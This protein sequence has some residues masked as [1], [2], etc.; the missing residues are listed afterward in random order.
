MRLLHHFTVSSTLWELLAADRSLTLKEEVL[1]GLPSTLPRTVIC[2]SM[3]NK[4]KT[5][6]VSGCGATVSTAK[7]E[8]VDHAESYY[9]E[10]LKDSK[11]E[12]P[13]MYPYNS[14]YSFELKRRK[15][16]N[17]EPGAVQ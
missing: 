9:D 8:S 7:Q 12:N 1:H 10:L 5:G 13:N 4:I 3:H 17:C 6:E 2:I 14:L 16:N 11:K 15:S